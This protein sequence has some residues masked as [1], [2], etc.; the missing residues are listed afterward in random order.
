MTPFCGGQAVRAPRKR[1]KRRSES[2]ENGE[3][4]LSVAASERAYYD[5]L[6]QH[7]LD[8]AYQRLKDPE[9]RAMLEEFLE[10]THRF[11]ARKSRGKE[12]QRKGAKHA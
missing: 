9:S 3:A 2:R 8:L 5:A 7:F 4:Q 1:T 12:Q 6:H 10:K 11:L